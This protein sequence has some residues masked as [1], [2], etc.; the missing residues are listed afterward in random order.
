MQTVITYQDPR[1]NAI[2]LTPKQVEMLERAGKWPRTRY[3]EYCTVSHGRH[4][5]YPTWTD[6]ELLIEVGIVPGGRSE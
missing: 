1:N 5:G 4:G 2:D 6:Q 3:G